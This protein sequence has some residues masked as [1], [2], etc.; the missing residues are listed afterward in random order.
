MAG[1]VEN[2]QVSNDVNEGNE[3]TDAPENINTGNVG[4]NKEQLFGYRAR[5]EIRPREVQRLIRH[6]GMTNFQQ[7]FVVFNSLKE[8]CRLNDCLVHI[9]TPRL[10]RMDSIFVK[11]A[12]LERYFQTVFE[13][14][15]EL[16]WPVEA[17]TRWPL[18]NVPKLDIS[19]LD[20]DETAVEAEGEN[21]VADNSIE[22]KIENLSHRTKHQQVRA[23]DND[24]SLVGSQRQ[25]PLFYLP[26]I[27]K[28]S[29]AGDD[30]TVQQW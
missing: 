7:C 5:G 20:F 21:G 29:S 23:E 24:D 8:A 2:N 30:D 19:H 27:R 18:A 26:G 10:M 16:T 4:E 28:N 3:R 13:Y 9:P 6:L 22:K 12:N 15:D 11:V 14:V 25:H 1:L 17:Q